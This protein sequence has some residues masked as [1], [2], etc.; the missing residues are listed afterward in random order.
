MLVLVLPD[1][2]PLLSPYLSH[3]LLPSP[4]Q[5]V[6]HMEHMFQ[7][8]KLCYERFDAQPGSKLALDHRAEP[9]RCK[10]SQLY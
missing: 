6:L 3:L 2:Y 4:H 7:H 1:C 8:W 9:A 10:F 5:F